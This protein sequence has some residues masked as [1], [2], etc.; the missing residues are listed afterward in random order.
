MFD[1]YIEEWQKD[2]SVNWIVGVESFF[3]H[4]EQQIEAVA[5]EQATSMVYSWLG[6]TWSQVGYSIVISY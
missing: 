4:S 2:F 3:N 5:L 6:G 1:K